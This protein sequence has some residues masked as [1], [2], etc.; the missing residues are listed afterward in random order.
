MSPS[1]DQGKDRLQHAYNLTL[2]SVAGQVGCLTLIIIIVALFVGLWLDDT[3][4][5]KPLFTLVLMIGSVPVTLILMFK[6][7]TTA[8]NHMKS[9]QPKQPVEKQEEETNRD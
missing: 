1:D 8:T 5:T 6:L 9:D 4:N 7:V 3:L 2:A